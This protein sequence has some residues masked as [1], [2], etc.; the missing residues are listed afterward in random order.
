MQGF[1]HLSFTQNETHHQHN[2]VAGHSSALAW[3]DVG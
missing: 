1:H 3:S 2:H